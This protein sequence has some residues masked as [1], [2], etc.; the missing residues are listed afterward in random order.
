MQTVF[1]VLGALLILQV[2]AS[3]ATWLYLWSQYRRP[4]VA[5]HRYWERGAYTERRQLF[6][7]AARPVLQ[8]YGRL[9]WS[10]V[11]TMLVILVLYAATESL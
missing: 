9:G 5:W 8:L 2:V 10:I 6:I 11:A 7:G 3:A 4:D 1:R